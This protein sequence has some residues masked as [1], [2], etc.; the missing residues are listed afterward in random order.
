MPLADPSLLPPPS[1]I[2]SRASHE[3]ILAQLQEIS[4]A[5]MQ[6][7]TPSAPSMGLGLGL[8]QDDLSF[9]QPEIDLLGLD[10][11]LLDGALS[12]DDMYLPLS[13]GQAG[14]GLNSM[15]LP[16]PGG[17]SIGGTNV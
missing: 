4:Q 6:P 15:D 17:R 16:L 14:M 10:G 5:S 7:P 13:A 3:N 8:F 2:P 9:A 12:L 11:G 1:T